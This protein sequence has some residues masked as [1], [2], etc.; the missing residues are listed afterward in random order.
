MLRT[1]RTT[2]SDHRDADC[3]A[4]RFEE[5]EVVT[6]VLAVVVDAVHEEFAAAE[7]LDRRRQLDH[8]HS[9]ALA[10]A[11]HSALIPA[12]CL[13]V[14]PT[15]TTR[16]RAAQRRL[17][18]I[19][20]GVAVGLGDGAHPLASRVD[21]SDDRLP[22]VHVRYLLDRRGSVL[23]ARAQPLTCNVDGIGADRNLIGARSEVCIGDIE[24]ARLDAVGV[25]KPTD[26]ATDGQRHKD[27]LARL[28]NDV[29]HRSVGQRAVAEAGYVQEGNLIGTL[30][31]VRL[32]EGDGLAEVTHLTATAAACRLLLTH[33]VLIS[34]RHDEIAGVVCTHVHARNHALAVFGGASL[35]RPG[36]GGCAG[37]RVGQRATHKVRKDAE[38]DSARFLW[39]ELACHDTAALHRRHVLLTIVGGRERPRLE[40]GGEP[41]TE[42]VHK[43]HSVV[44]CHAV[45]HVARLPCVHGIP[46]NLWHSTSIAALEALDFAWQEAEARHAWALLARLEECLQAK[47]DAKIWLVRLDTCA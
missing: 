20:D 21:R 12:E 37:G 34:F 33:V 14:W 15:Q 16:L 6:V 43:V 22:S 23:L 30:L 47:A 1:A 11:L 45:E 4:D 18:V 2:R 40:R 10:P 27:L 17:R 38:A 7:G 24:R 26:A 25:R 31:V 39:V 28:P 9:A 29:D 5:C 36:R 32:G 8:V 19:D 44:V 35:V 42:R 41:G 3:L 46:A 13:T